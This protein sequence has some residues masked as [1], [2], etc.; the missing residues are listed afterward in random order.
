MVRVIFEMVIW[1]ITSH[2]HATVIQKKFSRN[3]KYYKDVFNLQFKRVSNINKRNSG[4]YFKNKL[5]VD[6]TENLIYRHFANIQ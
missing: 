2:S 6:N 5:I 3:R 4:Q 1:P